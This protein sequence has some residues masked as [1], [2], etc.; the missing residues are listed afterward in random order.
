VT[1]ETRVP[2]STLTPMLPEPAADAASKLEQVVIEGNLAGLT[3]TQRV[4]Y[5]RAVCDSVG[6]NPLTKPFEYITLNGKLTLY[7]RAEATA[8]LR[9]LRLINITQLERSMN[10]ALGLYIVTAHGRDGEGR[11][12]LATGAVSV[13]GLKGETLANAIMK[14]ETKAKRRL[15][16]SLAGL[17]MLDELEADSV[18]GAW[19]A[20]VDVETGEIAAASVERLSLEER[21]AAQAEAISAGPVEPAPAPTTG[22]DE[23][24]SGPG[25]GVETGPASGLDA[26]AS[27]PRSASAPVGAGE[28]VTAEPAVDAEPAAIASPRRPSTTAEGLGTGEAQ[29]AEAGS[30]VTAGLSAGALRDWLRSNLIGISEARK[31]A[32]AA[33]GIDE[34]DKLTDAQRGELVELLRGQATE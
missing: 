27:P 20:D 15:T 31:V 1:I 13:A 19:R 29:E 7:A 9:K 10:D 11:E 32:K 14:A 28:P 21:I 25:T 34:I 3:P 24:G 26:T 4:M 16:L 22:S 23:A 12:D 8:Q 2:A 18:P 5:Y 17:G 33:F 30:A 6:L